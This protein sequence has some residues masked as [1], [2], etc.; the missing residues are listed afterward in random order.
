MDRKEHTGKDGAA[1]FADDGRDYNAELI[2]KIDAME[3][4]MKAAA[5]LKKEQEGEVT[6][7]LR[8]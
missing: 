5:A 2:A 3:Q 6:S 7:P 8:G 4:R 1:L